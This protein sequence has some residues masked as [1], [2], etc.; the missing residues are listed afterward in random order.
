MTEIFKIKTGIAP[1]RL[2]EV[3]EFTDASYNLRNQSKFNHNIPCT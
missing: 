1:E 2:K 3:F